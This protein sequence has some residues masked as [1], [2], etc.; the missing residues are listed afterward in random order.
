M[1][2]V[3]FGDEKGAKAESQDPN[4]RRCAV[5]EN[6]NLSLWMNKWSARSDNRK[7]GTVEVERRS[8]EIEKTI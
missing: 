4:P 5:M 1:D 2:D 3:L 7:P 8:K 6:L